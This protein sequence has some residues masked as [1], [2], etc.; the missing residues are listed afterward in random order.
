[1][2]CILGNNATLF[3]V[4]PDAYVRMRNRFSVSLPFANQNA[5][6]VSCFGSARA[7]DA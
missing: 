7:T 2:K 6:R 5:A 3:V 4:Q 1:M